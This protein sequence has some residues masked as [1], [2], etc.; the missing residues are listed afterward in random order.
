MGN[1]ALLQA[2]AI[3][4]PLLAVGAA[5]WRGGEQRRAGVAVGAAWIAST[6]VTPLR[7]PGPS[8]WLFSIDVM[9]AVWLLGMSRRTPVPWLIFTAANALLLVVNHVA[10]ATVVAIQDW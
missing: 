1:G 2:L 3:A 6:I 8:Y 10:F 4:V 7:L 9:L 5:V